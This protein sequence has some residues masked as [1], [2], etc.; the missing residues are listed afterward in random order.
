V[1]DRGVVHFTDRPTNRQFQA[2]AFEPRGLSSGIRFTRASVQPGDAD[3]YDHII[4][5]AAD[6]HR[7]PAALIKAV[8]AAESSFDP[9]AVS[10]KGAM[11]LM[12]LMPRTATELGVER[13][14]SAA[15]NVDGGARYL[16]VLH[17][18]YG[19]WF[20]TLAA[21]NAGPSA[22]DRYGGIPPYR[23][24]REY[25]ERVLTY[26]RRYDGDFSR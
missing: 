15:A 23:E 2:V 26:Y 9:E 10:R 1:D 4:S 18:R 24:T 3:A 20:R 6:E 19:D 21:Y 12:Q 22:V 14:F 11:G 25:V 8:V 16:R 5:A 13:P 7:V 17:D